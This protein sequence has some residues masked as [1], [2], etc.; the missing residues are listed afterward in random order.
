[1][2]KFL[3][4]F[5]L[6]AVP[7]WAA[8]KTIDQLTVATDHAAADKFPMWDTSANATK[9]LTLSTLW[10]LSHATGANAMGALAISTAYAVNTKS[11]SADSTF[12]FSGAP[13]TDTWFSLLLTTDATARVV[14][15]PSSY[16]MGSQATITSFTAP[17]SSKTFLTWHYN[18]STYELFGEPSSETWIIAVSD[19]TTAITTGTAKA[20]FRAPYACTVVAVFA[21]LNTVSSS[22]TP[23][24][25]IN[26]G[27]STILGNKLVI[28]A[29]ELTTDTAANAATITDNQLAA[30]ASITIDIDTAGTGAK[31]AK[32]HITVVH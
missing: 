14:T 21:E 23:T 6:F 8:D 25:D 24:F 4:I 31:G 22:G 32:V 2:K 16:S 28:D 1:M 12:T 11:I 15:I 7:L 26:E 19:E 5:C 17:P 27:G 30:H 20:T 13:P 9:G 10:A 3:L 18:G 29:S